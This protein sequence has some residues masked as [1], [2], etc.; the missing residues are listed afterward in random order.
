MP[1]VLLINQES[2]INLIKNMG[3]KASKINFYYLQQLENII[4]NFQ[5]DPNKILE[6]T[7]GRCVL[8][9]LLPI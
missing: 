1:K 7:L 8:Y 6:D 4:L 3:S 5:L 9:T 2:V